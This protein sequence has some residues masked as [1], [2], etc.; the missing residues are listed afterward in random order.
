MGSQ[1]VQQAA[2]LYLDDLFSVNIR[3]KLGIIAEKK[4]LLC[5]VFPNLLAVFLLL[6]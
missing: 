3:V 1:P 4:V 5:A 2:P 6:L